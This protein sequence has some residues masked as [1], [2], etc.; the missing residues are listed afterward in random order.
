MVRQRRHL[1]LEQLNRPGTFRSSASG[2]VRM[3]ILN[4]VSEKT[5]MGTFRVCIRW[6]ESI[7][8]VKENLS[9]KVI[10]PSITHCEN[11]RDVMMDPEQATSV[12]SHPEKFRYVSVEH[13]V[14]AL[15]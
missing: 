4:K 15:L 10:S 13:V 2:A 1:Q 9:E 14:I 7:D 11:A 8:G 3:E 5:Q 6:L 12:L